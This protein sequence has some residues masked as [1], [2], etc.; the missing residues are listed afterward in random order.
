MRASSEGD[1]V[2]SGWQMG[3]KLPY[4]LWQ[5]TRHYAGEYEAGRRD[6]TRAASQV[7]E[8]A[9]G[10]T[11]IHSKDPLLFLANGKGLSVRV[12]SSDFLSY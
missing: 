12:T 2:A 5:N 6:R 9:S 10:S 7:G 3:V 4:P 11:E 8:T 1:Q